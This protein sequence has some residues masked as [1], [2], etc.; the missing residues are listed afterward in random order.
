MKSLQLAVSVDNGFQL[1][2][3]GVYLT[4]EQGKVEFVI[5][6]PGIDPIADAAEARHA[7]L[8]AQGPQGIAAQVGRPIIAPS[9][10][11]PAACAASA[12]SITC[13]ALPLTSTTSGF[14]GA[15]ARRGVDG[16]SERTFPS[17]NY[18]HFLREEIVK[19]G[20]RPYESL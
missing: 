10:P 3:Q 17:R 1:L 18:C 2:N 9:A 11:I 4:S 6:Q 15:S 12:R 20:H 7:S 14:K 19:I 5:L 8:C 16:D 13:L